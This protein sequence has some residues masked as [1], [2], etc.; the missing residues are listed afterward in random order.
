MVALTFIEDWDTDT[1]GPFPVKSSRHA[2]CRAVRL[3]GPSG[4]YAGWCIREP[5]TIGKPEAGTERKLEPRYRAICLVTPSK[6]H[7]A[8]KVKETT[9]HVAKDAANQQREIA[10]AELKARR[11]KGE[12]LT[13]ADLEFMADLVTGRV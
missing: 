12:P 8:R 5:R 1:H 11:D 6:A 4:V 13:Q 7:A 3:D 9:E 2:G 10:K